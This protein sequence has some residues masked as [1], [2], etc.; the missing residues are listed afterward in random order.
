MSTGKKDTTPELRYEVALIETVQ[1]MDEWHDPF[2]LLASTVEW[3]SV[4]GPELDALHRGVSRVN[5]ERRDSH[6]YDSQFRLQVFRKPDRV[7]TP[8]IAEVL[9]IE[10]E[11][12]R[13]K[14]LAELDRK[15]TKEAREA[16]KFASM[17]KRV[18][19]AYNLT[20]EQVDGL[21]K[22]KIKALAAA[23]T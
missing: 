23:A 14:L 5:N 15:A 17:K 22:A 1:Y 2:H 8:T 4:T 16:V 20:L 7:V 3:V 18:M 6:G 10:R 11:A 9:V 21:S 13:V 12:E 19:A